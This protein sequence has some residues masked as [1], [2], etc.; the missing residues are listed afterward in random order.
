MSIF[1]RLLRRGPDTASTDALIEMLAARRVVGRAAE[2]AEAVARA[3]RLPRGT[4]AIAVV[5]LDSEAAPLRHVVA[6]RIGGDAAGHMGK[7]VVTGIHV[8]LD[9]SALPAEWPSDWSSVLLAQ[10]EDRGSFAW[11]PLD[12]TSAGASDAV[13]MLSASDRIARLV[14]VILNEPQTLQVEIAPSDSIVRVAAHHTGGELPPPTM[15]E[16]VLGIARAVAGV[17]V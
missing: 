3:L 4:R 9:R 6:S 13:A 17:E 15:L 10:P 11:R 12:A 5:A 2:D 14:S 16:A 8:T 7:I 1:R